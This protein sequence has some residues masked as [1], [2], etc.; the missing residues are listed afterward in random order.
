MGSS[1]NL[2]QRAAQE[3]RRVAKAD[4]LRLRDALPI[5]DVTAGTGLPAAQEEIIE[6]AAK[7]GSYPAGPVTRES[8]R[9]HLTLIATSGPAPCM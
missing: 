7:R 3:F 2:L 8:R 5:A 9:H 4:H 6:L 1:G